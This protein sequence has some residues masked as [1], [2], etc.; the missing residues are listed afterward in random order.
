MKD[1]MTQYKISLQFISSIH[2]LD[3]SSP[4]SDVSNQFDNFTSSSSKN[5]VLHTD[6]SDSLSIASVSS[7]GNFS[8][9]D[10]EGTVLNF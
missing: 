5:N 9:S 1:V 6:N 10:D 8:Y 3:L 7:C 2:N 4:E